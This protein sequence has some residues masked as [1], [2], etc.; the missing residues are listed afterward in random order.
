MRLILGFAAALGV[1][2]S[3]G[4]A[5]AGVYGDDLTRCLVSATSR[6]D[7]VAFTRWIFTAMSANPSVADLSNVSEDQRLEANRTTAN[8]MQRLILTDCRQQSLAAVR[9]EGEQTISDSFKMVGEV[10]MID[11]MNH[12]D[13]AAEL[14]SLGTL[15][16]A[17][18]WEAFGAELGELRANQP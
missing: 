8:L 4:V 10:A 6:E 16:D 5:S 7:R 1:F 14:E 17:S 12:P 15:L 11:L 18:A 2:A 9:Y 3:S 13:V